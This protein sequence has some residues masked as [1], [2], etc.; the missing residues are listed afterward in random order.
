MPSHTYRITVR[1]EK[2]IITAKY[3]S[4]HKLEAGEETILFYNGKSNLVKIISITK[5]I[6]A[7]IEA[8]EV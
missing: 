8:K 7:S 1:G 2:G 5:G 6:P 3:K 4:P